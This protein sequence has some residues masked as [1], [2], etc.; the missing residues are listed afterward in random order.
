[1]DI[2]G[3]DV[4]VPTSLSTSKAIE[5][6]VKAIE[7]VWGPSIVEINGPNEVFM[8]SSREAVDAWDAYGWNEPYAKSMI[9]VISVTPGQV[10]I[11]VDNNEDSVLLR[12]LDAITDA[13]K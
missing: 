10:T 9:D 5:V 13:L 6:A 1:M 8:Y 4:V 2:H 3:F 7:S 11:V 12:I